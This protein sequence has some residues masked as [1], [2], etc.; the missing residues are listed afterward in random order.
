MNDPEPGTADQWYVSQ[1]Q[2]RV[3]DL[4]R[5][6]K[7]LYGQ[8]SLMADIGTAGAE[9][10]ARE[11]LAT[12]A[13]AFWNAEDTDLEVV[14]HNEMDEY[15]KWVRETF[16]CHLKYESGSYHQRCPVAIAHKRVGMSVGFTV[17]RRICSICGDDW[18]DCV[19]LPSVLYDVPGGVNDEG[20]CAVC[21]GENCIEHLPGQTYRT[22]PI[23]IVVEA[24]ELRE[25]SFVRKPAYADARITSM[26]VDIS[27]LGPSF[28]IGTAINC[29]RCIQPCMGIEEI[30]GL[31]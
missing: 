24:E 15:G 3:N 8:S 17:R 11:M 18:A 27:A 4:R 12:A 2:K 23:A 19:H 5:Q 1:N 22:P 14:T 13:S 10:I 31:A 9:S 28:P 21:T 29:N 25:V 16:G 6:A 7:R 20:R 30:P 26:P